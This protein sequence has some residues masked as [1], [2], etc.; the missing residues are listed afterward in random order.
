GVPAVRDGRRRR[1]VLHRQARPGGD[2]E[3]GGGEDQGHLREVRLNPVPPAAARAAAGAPSAGPG[4]APPEGR[5]RSAVIIGDGLYGPS[6]AAP[7]TGARRLADVESHPPA[8][9]S[10]ASSGCRRPGWSAGLT[11]GT[12]PHPRSARWHRSSSRI[13]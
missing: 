10:G 13:W 3:V 5:T 11:T 2:G 8:V 6:A 12:H 1:P 4:P 9:A 7:L